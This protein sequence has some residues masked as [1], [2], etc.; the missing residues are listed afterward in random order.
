MEEY[1]VE[2]PLEIRILRNLSFLST[3]RNRLWCNVAIIEPVEE[4]LGN[5]GGKIRGFQSTLF[6]PSFTRFYYENEEVIFRMRED[7]PHGELKVGDEVYHVEADQ[8][9]KNRK[10]Q[11]EVKKFPGG[12]PELWDYL[13]QFAN[14][15]RTIDARPFG[16]PEVAELT[17]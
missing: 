16:W 10:I 1:N 2:N 4:I 3:G 11:Y 6:A 13:S 7:S 15:T 14:K 8:G 12:Y 17:R 5:R 9:A